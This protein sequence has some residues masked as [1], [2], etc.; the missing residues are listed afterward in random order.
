MDPV[1]GPAHSQRGAG[2]A[3]AFRGPG[4][5]G[6]APGP[7]DRGRGGGGS[8]GTCGGGVLVRA[9]FNSIANCWL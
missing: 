1:H 2:S 7:P 5:G 8:F 6:V 3:R 4:A 9:S